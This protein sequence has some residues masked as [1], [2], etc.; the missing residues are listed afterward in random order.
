MRRNMDIL[1]SLLVSKR[2]C[3]VTLNIIYR[4]VTLPHSY[5]FS[6]FLSHISDFPELGSLVKRL[7]LSHFNSIGLGRT[8]EMNLE[9]QNLTSDTLLRCLSLTPNLQ[10]LL[11]QEHLD[12]DLDQAVLTKVLTGLP[13]LRALDLCAS[14]AGSFSEAFSSAVTSDIYQTQYSNIQKLGLHECF[15]ISSS[16]LE[17]LLRRMPHLK[18]LD[19]YHT[20]VTIAALQSIPHTARLTHLNLGLCTNIT[21]PQVTTFLTAHP[22]AARLV[23]LNLACDL[24]RSRLLRNTDLDVLLPR[25]P[26]SLR[27]LNLAG[28]QLR[29]ETHMP[30]LLRLSKHLEELGLGHTEL[31]MTDIK[32]FF[33]PPRTTDNDSPK[34]SPATAPPAEQWPS[35]P[36]TLHYLD[37]TGIPSVTQPSLFFDPPS[38][39]RSSRID[40]PLYPTS[41][42]ITPPLPFLL[43]PASYPLE[44]LELSASVATDLKRIE[45]SNRRYGWLVKELGR[46]AWYV[47]ETGARNDEGDPAGGRKKGERWWK[48]GC[49][50]WGMRKVNVVE[51][52]VGGLY[53]WHMFRK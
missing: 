38:P 46:R 53:G 4:K 9:I 10:E 18:I 2:L 16:D 41:A 35:Q 27:S 13:R 49:R 42:P 21:G 33:Q 34:D 5:V 51:G 11:L 15:T 1:A 17:A 24:A 48:M 29:A 25:L 12:Q 7:D 14:Y 20:R 39:Q 45:R 52:E 19:L 32:S 50:S 31:S 6:K 30:H 22:A 26:K 23:H 3:S 28:A 43:S 36:C 37:L 40:I 47:S 44:V 8:R